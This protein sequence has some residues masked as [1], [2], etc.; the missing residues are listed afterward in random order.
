M[1]TNIYDSR[2]VSVAFGALLLTENRADPFCAIT[3]PQRFDAEQSVDGQLM[4]FFTGD[5]L[6]TVELTFKG[7]SKHNQE[8]SAIHALDAAA[9]NGAGVGALLIKDNNG[10]TLIASDKAWIAKAPDVEFGQ[11]RGDQTWL[12]QCELPAPQAIVGGN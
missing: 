6:A 9:T 3:P 5:N 7:S 8:L 2:A 1:A 4:R 12:L 10:A 11:T